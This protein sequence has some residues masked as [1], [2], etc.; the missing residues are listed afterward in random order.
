MEAWKLGCGLNVI[1]LR[2]KQGSKYML[3]VTSH[4]IIINIIIIII[5]IIIGS[6]SR[7]IVY[8]MINIRPVTQ[9]SSSN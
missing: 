7:L 6:R 5:I 9:L 3:L 4:H 1:A 8:F 2:F